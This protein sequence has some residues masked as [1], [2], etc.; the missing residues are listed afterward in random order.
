VAQ[1]KSHLHT[2]VYG[3][4]IQS[5]QV[6]YAEALAQSLGPQLDHV[7]FVNSGSEATEGAL[8]LAK[9]YTGRSRIVAFHQ[10]YHGSTH[11]SLSVTGADWLKEG[12]GPFLPGVSF[13]HFNDFDSL[14]AID[15][16]TACVIVEPIQA[17]AGVRMPQ[18][19]FLRALRD[20]CTEVGALLIFDEI[21]TGMGRTGSLFAYQAIQVTPD[22]LTLGK[23]LGGGMPL[24]A[25]LSRGEVMQVLTHDPVLGLITTFGGHPVSCAAG[26]A[27]FHKIQREALPQ[28]AAEWGQW[29]RPRLRHPLLGEVRGMGLLLAVDFHGSFTEL[30]AVAKTCWKNGLLLDWFLHNG[31]AFRWAPPL[32]INQEEL[33]LAL[34]LFLNALDE[35]SHFLAEQR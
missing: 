15:Q 31:Q 3:E 33:Q 8:K 12:Y 28:R 34:D 30:L 17:E 29:L 19:G 7:Y 11:G 14:A 26:L 2:M 5:P 1:A 4:H 21:Q 27:A 10:S 18:P 13:L 9:K 32:T 35:H 22:I 24:G 16:T 20:R 6:R 23:A 25:F